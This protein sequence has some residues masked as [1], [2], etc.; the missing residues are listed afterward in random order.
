M[1]YVSPKRYQQCKAQINDYKYLNNNIFTKILAADHK[2]RYNII[3]V[4]Y[5]TTFVNFRD[6][7]F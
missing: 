3:F 1:A 5:A 4:I 7:L 6:E 2:D